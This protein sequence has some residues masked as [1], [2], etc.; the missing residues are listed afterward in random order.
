MCACVWVW[1]RRFPFLR[2]HTQTHT[3]KHPSSPFTLLNKGKVE[4]RTLRTA[5]SAFQRVLGAPVQHAA[6]RA[7]PVSRLPRAPRLCVV[8]RKV[9]VLPVHHR[10]VLPVR[11]VPL[12][13]HDR[14]RLL[15]AALV[16]DGPELAEPPTAALRLCD[17]EV[18]EVRV[19]RQDQIF[20]H[21][22]RLVDRLQ[23]RVLPQARL[24]ELTHR[25]PLRHHSHVL[26]PVRVHVVRHRDLLRHLRRLLLL[27]GC[28]CLPPQRCLLL[29][30]PCLLCA[31]H[32]HHRRRV[33][34][35]LRLC[36]VRVGVDSS[37]IVAAAATAG[38]SSALG[39]TFLTV[40]VEREI[41]LRRILLA[42]L[43]LRAPRRR[44]GNCLQLFAFSAELLLC[45]QP[46]RRLCKAVV[47]RRGC[48]VE[49]AAQ[50]LL[51]L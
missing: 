38:S 29:V 16:K 42:P 45:D 37:G 3:R 50:G 18:V 15:P 4:L 33:L 40:H 44:G 1:V 48:G 35:A 11:R 46:D 28:L 2:E 39:L 26:A 10:H 41:R 14:R 31:V 19:V 23:R 13:A 8:L 7:V 12:R 34:A 51:R 9:K 17:E 47:Q 43:R 32:G 25:R 30:A 36:L 5:A 22:H 49:G 20:L 6:R 21:E 27:K 24:H